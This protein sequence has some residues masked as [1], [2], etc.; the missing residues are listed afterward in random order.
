[1]PGPMDWWSAPRPRRHPVREIVVSDA[2]VTLADPQYLIA[3]LE[4]F[5]VALLQT[6]QFARADIPR[7]ALLAVAVCIYLGEVQNG[8]HAQVIENTQADATLFQ[9]VRE[10]L[11]LLGLDAVRDTWSKFEAYQKR[12]SAKF[13]AADWRDPEL[14]A[15]DDA[16]SPKLK[17]AFAHI[18]DEAV[19]WPFMR[20][21]SGEGAR[22]ALD[23]IAAD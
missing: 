19:R 18:A 22:A 9:D 4:S 14:Q 10:G 7:E 2:Y 11:S 15:L 16:L 23:A 13:M 1:M 3:E 5:V 8:G 12:D 20:V 17:A 6:G 21:T